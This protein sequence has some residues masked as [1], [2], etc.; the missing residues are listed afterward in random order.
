MLEQIYF[1]NPLS[2]WITFGF[3]VIGSI[4]LGWLT[5]WII[6]SLANRS[7]YNLI[8]IF[9]QN[10]GRFALPIWIFF[11]LQIGVNALTLTSAASDYV[12][13]SLAFGFSIIIIFMVLK[14][15]ETLHNHLLM[16]MAKKTESQVDDH[17][18]GI[19]RMAIRT[20]VIF[21]GGLMAISNAGF[22]VGAALAGLGIGGLALAL[23][24]QD[25]VANFFGGITV[26]IEKPFKIG[27]LV[28]VDD[29]SGYVRDIGL[30]TTLIETTAGSMIRLPNKQ[31]TD[32]AIHLITYSETLFRIEHPII[33][34]YDTTVEKM[35]EAMN[36]LKNIIAKDEETTLVEC[37]FK[38]FGE[39]GFAFDFEYEINGWT[40]EQKSTFETPRSKGGSV[41]T[42]VN[43]AIMEQFQKN[44]I[45]IGLPIAEEIA[46]D[47]DDRYT[48]GVF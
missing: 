40:K 38:E 25:A 10:L 20:L 44:Q 14:A 48:K 29:V 8:R 21:L 5:Q 4:L 13:R 31:F 37:V 18:L 1:G 43:F 11:G 36:I 3:I 42:R 28:E 30:R 46:V 34:R 45:K 33:L 27:D 19:L 41:R 26:I 24:A 47:G 6:T 39:Y 22:D 12:S 7:K 16:P 23:A 15:Y 2:T 9:G 17:L 35:Q 32:N